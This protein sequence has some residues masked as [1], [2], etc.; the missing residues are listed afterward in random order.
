MIRCKVLLEHP[1]DSPCGKDICCHSCDEECLNRCEESE[2]CP[3]KVV[4]PDGLQV[5][6]KAVPDKIQE[7]TDL[8]IQVKKAEDRIN[9]IK[10]S[11]L[12][13]MEEQGIKKFENEKVS[14]T[15]VAP[16]TRKT[17]DKKKLE[18]EHPEL[19]LNRYNKESKVSASVRIKVK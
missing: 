14:F 11:L 4:E 8:M 1:E 7:V 10:E 13:A 9:E 3:D 6:E 2:D 5:M 18:K 12:K 19:D 17:F 15:Y 16:S